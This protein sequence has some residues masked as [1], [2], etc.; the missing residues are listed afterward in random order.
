MTVTRRKNAELVRCFLSL[1][2]IRN[3]DGIPE[4]R[5]SASVIFTNFVC[6]TLEEWVK[7]QIR[8]GHN[9]CIHLAPRRALETVRG[10]SC[11]SFGP[12]H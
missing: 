8:L 6:D 9:A 12:C 4:I 3:D 2:L 7:T 5:E 1:S 10:P 11:F